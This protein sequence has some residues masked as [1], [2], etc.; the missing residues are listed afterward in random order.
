DEF[1]TFMSL[2]ADIGLTSFP[3]SFQRVEVLIEA[4]LGRLAGV[5][6]TAESS[7]LAHA[8]SP[9]SWVVAR[10]LVVSGCLG[11]AEAGRSN[12]KNLGPDH[13]VPVMATAVADN[14]L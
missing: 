4:L 13:L 1:P 10:T 8:A 2:R 5:D 11:R 12:P 14:V 7:L 3:L 9:C 6:R